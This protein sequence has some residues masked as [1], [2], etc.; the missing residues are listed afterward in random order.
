MNH[1]A[2]TGAPG[3]LRQDAFIASVLLP[4]F[5]FSPFFLILYWG[6]NKHGVIGVI[7]FQY[8][9]SSL[10]SHQVASLLSVSFTKFLLDGKFGCVY[11]NSQC[12]AVSIVEA[13]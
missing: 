4:S 2:E 6:G 9:T 8:T 7:A 5:F 3:E 12:K 10:A 13:R 11:I 1:R